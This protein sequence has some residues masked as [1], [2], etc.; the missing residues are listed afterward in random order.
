MTRYKPVQSGEW[1]QPIR[2]G[3]RMRCCDC[4]LVHRLD[5][6]IIKGRV[7]FRAFRHERATAQCR[8]KRA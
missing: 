6:R 3:Y 7:Q 2:K 5:F 4:A 8:R 1:V